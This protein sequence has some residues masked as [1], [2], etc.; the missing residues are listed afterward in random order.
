MMLDFIR[1]LKD[2]IGKDVRL[3][4]L[5]PDGQNQFEV[6]GRVKEFKH[7]DRVLIFELGEED[8]EKLGSKY[9]KFNLDVVTITAYDELECSSS[10]SKKHKKKNI[11]SQIRCPQCD[12]VLNIVD[13][14]ALRE[15]SEV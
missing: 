4:F 3:H 5:L 2:D 9:S 14:S 12:E 8:R 10:D 15:E 1:E 13:G 7:N 6:E 11:I